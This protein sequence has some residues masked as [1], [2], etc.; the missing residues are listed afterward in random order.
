MLGGSYAGA[1]P[2]FQSIG[3]GL[4]AHRAA[5]RGRRC[6]FDRSDNGALQSITDPSGNWI[7]YTYDAPGRLDSLVFGASGGAVLLR[8]CGITAAC[9]I[10]PVP[11][12]P[13]RDPLE[14]PRLQ[15]GNWTGSALVRRLEA[16]PAARSPAIRKAGSRT[17][18][19]R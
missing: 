2:S 3:V 16:L 13:G 7:R 17:S 6:L 18:P 4:R 12:R 10:A 8:R 9:V 11:V 15:V 5:A 19:S 1:D 14:L